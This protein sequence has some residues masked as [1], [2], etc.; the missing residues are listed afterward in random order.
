MNNYGC[1]SI[2]VMLTTRSPQWHEV[3]RRMK[4]DIL[5]W[6]AEQDF[7]FLEMTGTKTKKID[8]FLVGN[9]YFI[10]KLLDEILMRR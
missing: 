10:S 6:K 7:S 5:L 1:Q 4:G 9:I 8:Q 2:S 3:L